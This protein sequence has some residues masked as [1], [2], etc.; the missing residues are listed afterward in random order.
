MLLLLLLLL[1][2]LVCLLYTHPGLLPDMALR[3]SPLLLLHNGRCKE[4]ETKMN[5][6]V[7]CW[8]A[9]MDT[10]QDKT[11]ND[12]PLG[13]RAESERGGESSARANV[14]LSFERK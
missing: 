4:G 2:L 13:G 3:G 10:S 12:S 9:F 7:E 6:M 5:V 14:V 1:L 11:H 8:M